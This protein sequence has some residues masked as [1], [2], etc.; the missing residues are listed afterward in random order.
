MDHS[1]V[2]RHLE[3]LHRAAIEP[4]R[5]HHTLAPPL[6]PRYAQTLAALRA[7]LDKADIALTVVVMPLRRSVY[8]AQTEPRRSQLLGILRDAG[9]SVID[10]QGVVD[11]AVSAGGESRM[12]RDQPVGDIHLHAAGL[13]LVADW[14]VARM[15]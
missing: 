5:A 12:Y 1:F 7:S 15:P 14:L 3:S 9:L 10:T 8:G 2:A 6:N 11:E 4:A 13:S